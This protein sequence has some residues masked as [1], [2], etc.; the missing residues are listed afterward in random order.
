MVS[1]AVMAT[2]YETVGFAKRCVSVAVFVLLWYEGQLE[3]GDMGGYKR[4]GEVWRCMQHDT[5]LQDGSHG[6]QEV[7]T[8]NDA[9]IHQWK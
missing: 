6:D 3:C 1:Y 2:I 5:S 7:I 8:V 4:F 9:V